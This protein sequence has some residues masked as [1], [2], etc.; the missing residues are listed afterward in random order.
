MRE[1]LEHQKCKEKQKAAEA[2]K[3]VAVKKVRESAKGKGK[4]KDVEDGEP[5]LTKKK[6]KQIVETDEE[7]DRLEMLLKKQV[8]AEGS[9]GSM[10]VFT[11]PHLFLEE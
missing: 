10:E 9:G 11:L 1:E 5:E 8:K 4:A 3:K 2:A 6:S 7:G